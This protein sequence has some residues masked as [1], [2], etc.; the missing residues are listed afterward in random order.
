VHEPH[1]SQPLPTDSALLTIIHRAPI[2][3]SY[4]IECPHGVTQDEAGGTDADLARNLI[5]GLMARHGLPFGCTCTAE[6]DLLDVYPSIEFAVDQ[7]SAG[8]THGLADIDQHV[9]A[10]LIDS[11]DGSRC[12]E[13]SIAV[14]VLPLH[15]PLVVAPLHDVRCPNSRDGRV[16]PEAFLKRG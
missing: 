13:C 12:P 3:E 16:L 4:V 9:M 11:I 15:F 6:T 1:G 2:G 14:L 10:G 7:I 8:S 5:A